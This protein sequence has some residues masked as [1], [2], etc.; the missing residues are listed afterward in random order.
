M[1]LV[2]NEDKYPPATKIAGMG[3]NTSR[4]ILESV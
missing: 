1:P 2:V 3:K 4:I